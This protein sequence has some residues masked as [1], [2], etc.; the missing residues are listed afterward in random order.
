MLITSM[1]VLKSYIRYFFNLNSQAHCFYYIFLKEHIPFNI[2]TNF[3]CTPVLERL[4]CVRD[5]ITCFRIRYSIYIEITY[6]QRI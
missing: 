6:V 2:Y 5:V 4:E 3:R 1:T